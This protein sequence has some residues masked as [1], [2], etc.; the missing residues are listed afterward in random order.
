MDKADDDFC[1]VLKSEMKARLP[2]KKVT[3]MSGYVCNKKRRVGKPWW[4][5]ILTVLGM[6]SREDAVKM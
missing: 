6:F 4:N 3:L 2:C 1:A 5:D